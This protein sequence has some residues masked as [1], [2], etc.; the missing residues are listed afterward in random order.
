MRWALAEA[1]DKAYVVEPSGV[2]RILHLSDAGQLTDGGMLVPLTSGDWS[3]ELPDGI[4][5]PT[6]GGATKL[7]FSRDRETFA[8]KDSILPSI[9]L[10]K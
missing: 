7:A 5:R 3:M 2:I 8:L 10:T 1:E 4:I 9:G 6:P